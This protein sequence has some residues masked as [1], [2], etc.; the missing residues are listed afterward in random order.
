MNNYLDF[1]PNDILLY[2]IIFP[3][4]DSDD[5][6]NILKSNIL[7]DRDELWKYYINEYYQEVFHK[8]NYYQQTWEQFLFLLLNSEIV[9]VYYHNRVVDFNIVTVD[10][11]LGYLDMDDSE[12]IIVFLNHSTNLILKE[13]SKFLV[14]RNHYI[15]S[16]YN[17]QS[18]NGIFKIVLL[19]ENIDDI[20]EILTYGFI[21]KS[22]GLS[23]IDKSEDVSDG[24]KNIRGRSC[25]HTKKEDLAIIL[26]KL[27]NTTAK[28]MIDLVLNN[29]VIR[30]S[31]CDLIHHR[32]QEINHIN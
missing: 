20:N 29:D 3:Y 32:L 23:L 7:S 10:N 12:K 16:K 13:I 31:L 30:I 4:L 6:N 14:I 26:S 22:G 25:T 18:N 9:P 21:N 8:K 5:M 28:D 11:Y 15:V 24:R 27:Y 1:L 17:F 2:N 19:D